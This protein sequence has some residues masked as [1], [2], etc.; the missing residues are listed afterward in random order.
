MRPFHIA[1]FILVFIVAAAALVALGFTMW[2]RRR[3]LN[4]ENAAPGDSE[5][6]EQL[7]SV[8][9]VGDSEITILDQQTTKLTTTTN[10]VGT[11][12]VGTLDYDSVKFVKV[13]GTAINADGVNAQ[14]NNQITMV[15]QSS[16][17]VDP[18]TTVGGTVSGA[19]I[20][21]TVSSGTLE[22]FVVSPTTDTLSWT[23]YVTLQP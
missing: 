16:V 23:I 18:L 4:N 20:S 19:Q 7:K 17:M 1:I 14:F 15:S 21:L 13:E 6:V 22:V 8:I 9:S 12:S 5:F 10:A 11:F 2:T 3:V